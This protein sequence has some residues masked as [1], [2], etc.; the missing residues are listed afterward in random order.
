MNTLMIN[1]IEYENLEDY[2]QTGILGFCE[3]GQAENNLLYVLGG[4]ELINAPKVDCWGKDL[5]KEDSDKWWNDYK[6]RK[7]A[8]F[9]NKPAEYFFFYWTDKQGL[10]DHG[11]SVPGWL[12]ENGYKL[13]ELLKKW[14]ETEFTK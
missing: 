3:C 12:N 6:E 5:T 2:I 8:H 13:L 4:L 7:L 10:T 14:K 9:G 1:D 11:G